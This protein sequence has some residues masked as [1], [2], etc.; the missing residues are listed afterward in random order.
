MVSSLNYARAPRLCVP[1]ELS[2]QTVRRTHRLEARG[3]TI[4]CLIASRRRISA[5][6]QRGVVQD[7]VSFK[8][9]QRK[10]QDDVRRSVGSAAS[11][12]LEELGWGWHLRCIRCDRE[13]KC[14]H[15]T[16][17][18]ESPPITANQQSM[19]T[20]V[21]AM[22]GRNGL[23]SPTSR[24]RRR[25]GK[26]KSRTNTTPSGPSPVIFQIA[27][28]D[29]SSVRPESTWP[30]RY[31][32]LTSRLLSKTTSALPQMICLAA[33]R[34]VLS[35]S[36]LLNDFRRDYER[37]STHSPHC[38]S[39]AGS[40]LVLSPVYYLTKIQCHIRDASRISAR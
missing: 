39:A 32:R 37:H 11:E 22:F 31:E 29:L 6:R 35:R 38:V 17:S 40:A 8:R 10:W 26:A 25:V 23:H 20:Q 16:M 1:R 33:R 12:S 36:P 2:V 19:H 14:A 34:P 4:F 30:D 3:A 28:C 27:S 13:E 24:C 9:Y 5:I 21:L 18:Q 15:R 7:S